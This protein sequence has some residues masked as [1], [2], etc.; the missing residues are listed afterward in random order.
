MMMMINDDRYKK[1]VYYYPEGSLHPPISIY[2]V[3]RKTSR[4]VAFRGGGATFKAFLGKIL[5]TQKIATKSAGQL[6]LSSFA[7]GANSKWST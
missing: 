7:H 3:Q 2:I 4:A 5:L 1:L 6:F